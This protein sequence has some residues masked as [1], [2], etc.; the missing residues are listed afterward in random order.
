MVYVNMFS[1]YS[2]H[3]AENKPNSQRVLDSLSKDV[4]SYARNKTINDT[5]IVRQ[6]AAICNDK[7]IIITHPIITDDDIHACASWGD[8]VKN[9]SPIK[10]KYSSLHKSFISLTEKQAVAK[11]NLPTVN[12]EPTE[13][14]HLDKTQV[15]PVSIN[16]LYDIDDNSLAFVVL[17]QLLPIPIGVSVPTKNLAD[18]KL[19]DCKD[20]PVAYYWAKAAKYLLDHNGGHCLSAGDTI[21]QASDVKSEININKLTSGKT[22]SLSEIAMLDPEDDHFNLVIKNIIAEGIESIPK[23]PEKVTSPAA[24][25]SFGLPRNG[26]SSSK[27]ENT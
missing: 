15:S 17:P 26:E 1:S 16:F 25:Q 6:F 5:G 18:L 22:I 4:R 9:A 2:D 23:E 14:E 11:F 27:R 10:F 20:W 7:V 3:F 13:L 12:K 24:F 8:K 19:E 21:F